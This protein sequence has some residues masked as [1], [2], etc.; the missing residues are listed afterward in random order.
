MSYTLLCTLAA[1]YSHLQVCA[2]TSAFARRF[3][4]DKKGRVVKR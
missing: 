3:L 1:L 4:V 2:F